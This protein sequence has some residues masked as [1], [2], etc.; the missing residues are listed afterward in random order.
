MTA[1]N[2]SG[3]C[4]M[5]LGAVAPAEDHLLGTLQG[6]AGLRALS[7]G[8]QWVVGGGRSGDLE[9]ATWALP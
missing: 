2:V 7:G 1:Q 4:Q 6:L 9:A 8:W 3:H 5:A